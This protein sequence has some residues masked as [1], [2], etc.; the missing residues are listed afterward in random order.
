MGEGEL[1]AGLKP[2]RRKVVFTVLI[3]LSLL[4]HPAIHGLSF[5]GPDTQEFSP[6]SRGNGPA[7]LQNNP[8]LC[9]PCQTASNV[10]PQ[11]ATALPVAPDSTGEILFLAVVSGYSFLSFAPLSARAPPLV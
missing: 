7:T 5:P 9:V 1:L 10:L 4:A 2:M 3:L 6:L 11:P 8:G